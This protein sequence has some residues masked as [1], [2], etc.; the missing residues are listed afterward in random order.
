[1]NENRQ[2]DREIENINREIHAHESL[3]NPNIIKLYHHV[4]VG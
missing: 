4:R 3:N 2:T 1:M